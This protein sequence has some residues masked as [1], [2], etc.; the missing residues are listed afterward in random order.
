MHW[1][2]AS[3]SVSTYDDVTKDVGYADLVGTLGINWNFNKFNGIR[4]YAGFRG[5]FIRRKS[6]EFGKSTYPMVGGVIGVDFNLTRRMFDA[7]VMIGFRLWT[8]YRE[9]QKNQF[10]GDSDG[11]KRGLLTNNPLLQE[12]GAIVFTLYW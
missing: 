10:Y 12:N 6:P 3:A 2:F 1:G 9:D 5:G 4:Y 7:G 8:D 11:Y